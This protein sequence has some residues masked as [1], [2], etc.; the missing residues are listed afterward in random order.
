MSGYSVKI[1]PIF[2]SV[3]VTSIC[4][5]LVQAQ[6]TNETLNQIQQYTKEGRQDSINQI[7]NVNRL[8]D[9]S[10]TDWSYEALRSLSERYSDA[11]SLAPDGDAG[12]HRC[13][14]GLPNSTYQGDRP[15]TRNEFA[16]GLNSCFEYIERSLT[17]PQK[18][19]YLDSL[20][21]YYDSLRVWGF[22]L[23]IIE[24]DGSI[25]TFSDTGKN[26]ESDLATFGE[27]VDELESRI[28]ILE[29]NQF[30]PTTKFTG[31]TVFSFSNTLEGF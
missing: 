9:V 22:P 17:S 13:I 23:R 12:S 20:Q 16:A 5:N 21:A 27:E 3:L 4:G 31:E 1:T 30:S 18:Q 10:P 11:R 24:E 14:S 6:T 15:I 8:R 7:T 26:I 25:S 28:D 29:D 19:S 2:L